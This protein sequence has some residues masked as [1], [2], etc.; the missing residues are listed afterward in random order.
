MKVVND[1][2]FSYTQAYQECLSAFGV[3][4]VDRVRTA[5]ILLAKAVLRG[6]T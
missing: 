5:G 6:E 2:D 4:E 3:S 1:S